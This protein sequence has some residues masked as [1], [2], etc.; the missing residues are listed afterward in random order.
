MSTGEPREGGLVRWQWTLYPD[1]HRDRTNLLIHAVTVPLFMMGTM[2][3][4]MTPL[5]GAYGATGLA[6]MI[7][8]VAAQGRGHER[9]ATRPV[10]FRGPLDVVARLFVEQWVTFP[11]YVL[12]G[13]FARAW[14][15]N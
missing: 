10:P 8:A 5:L 6:G 4:A 7:V 1:G 3:L 15:G 11:R 14:R 9:E 13:A 2:T 12:S